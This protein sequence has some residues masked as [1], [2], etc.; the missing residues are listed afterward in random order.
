MT[1]NLRYFAWT[2]LLFVIELIIGI[3]VHD[4]FIRPYIGDFLV[5]ILI[6]CFIKSFFKISVINAAIFVLLFSFLVETLQYLNFVEVIGLEKYK[7]AKIII[8]NSFSWS[9][10]FAYIAGIIVTLSMEYFVQ[11]KKQK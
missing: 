10:I 2:C 9:D 3:F 7:I 8:G 11:L 4:S 6:Y 5:V 1:F